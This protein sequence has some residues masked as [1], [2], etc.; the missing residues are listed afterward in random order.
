MAIQHITTEE[1]WKQ[2]FVATEQQPLLLL[3]HSTRCPV[4][5]AALEEFEAYERDGRTDLVYAIVLVVEHR[6]ISLQIAE[7][8]GLKH[9]SPQI[10]FIEK[11]EK[12]W[13]ANHW[14]VTKRHMKAVL[15]DHIPHVHGG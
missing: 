5:T 2:L 15:D 14:A 6:P 3:K 1:Q 9:E 11:Q 13:S 7:D 4:S 12:V 8:I 10:L